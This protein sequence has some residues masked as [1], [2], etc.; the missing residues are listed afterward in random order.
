YA[1]QI[2]DELI[3][4][5]DKDPR[6]RSNEEITRLITEGIHKHAPDKQPIVISD[7]IESIQHAMEHAPRGAFVVICCDKVREI[8][9]FV[10]SEH[11]KE[12]QASGLELHRMI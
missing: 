5:H 3:I 2:F 8:L 6:G 7:E 12:A 10:S 9:D 1:S 4:K 11:N